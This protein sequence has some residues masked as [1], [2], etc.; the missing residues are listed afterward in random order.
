MTRFNRLTPEEKA[1][2]AANRYSPYP[3]SGTPLQNSRLK[4]ALDLQLEMASIPAISEQ[5][6][7]QTSAVLNRASQVQQKSLPRTMRATNANAFISPQV[8]QVMSS[9]YNAPA[10]S[11]P[12]VTVT[13]SSASVSV[14][15]DTPVT[16]APSFQPALTVPVVESP[17]EKVAPAVVFTADE[18]EVAKESAEK[19]RSTEKEHGKLKHSG[20]KK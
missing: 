6:A 15:K 9:Y 10:P 19:A 17:A 12:I 7:Q 13:P 8:S 16:L 14:A 20:K 18:P 3:T 4:A 11:T 5:V 2:Q 1:K